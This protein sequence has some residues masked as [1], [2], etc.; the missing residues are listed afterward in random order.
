M[1]SCIQLIERIFNYTKPLTGDLRLGLIAYRKESDANTLVDT[2][3]FASDAK[4]LSDAL[5]PSL[6]STGNAGTTPSSGSEDPVSTAL[7]H[8]L[9]LG[10]R[11]ESNKI[12]VLLVHRL[13]SVLGTHKLSTLHLY[14]LMLNRNALNKVHQDKTPF[15]R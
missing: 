15:V 1:H 7:D 4:Q 13:P 10:W 2:I 12:V 5:N 8:A 6:S 11:D 14:V 9:N 3:P